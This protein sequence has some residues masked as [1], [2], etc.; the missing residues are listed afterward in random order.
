LALDYRKPHSPSPTFHRRRDRQDH[1]FDVGQHID[2]GES[3][4]PIASCFGKCGSPG[5]GSKGLFGHVLSTIDLNGQSD[6]RAGEIEEKRGYG[7]LAAK[8]QPQQRAVPQMTPEL[9]FGIRG[10]TPQSPG[11]S[12]G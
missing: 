1:T 10:F 6:L 2:V 11:E 3:H 7:M 4:N 5:V 12:R 9:S 8:L